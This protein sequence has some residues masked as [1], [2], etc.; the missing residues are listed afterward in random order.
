MNLRIRSRALVLTGAALLAVST[1]LPPG[2]AAAAPDRTHRPSGDGLSAVIRYTEYGIPHIVA[3]DYPSL[4][5]GEGWA[6]AADQVCVLADGFVTGRGERS[7]Y[8][9]PDAATDGS[10]SSAATNLT[11]D[12]FFRGINAAGTVEKLLAQPAPTGPS[13]QA[14]ELMRGYAAGYNAWLRQHR[15]TD[16]AC[17]GA[18]WVKPITT[19]AV[20]RHGYALALLSGQGAAVDGITGARPPVAGAQPGQ[21]P[22]RTAERRT[23][24][25]VA[26]ARRHFDRSRA[27]M[28][29]NAVAFSG[30]TTANGR[31]LL[32]GN[33]H[34]PWHGG[35][36]FWQSQVT[37]PGE[38]DAAGG[39]LL[40]VTSIS[41]GHNSRIAWSHTVAMGVPLT[42]RELTLVPNDP[43]S[44]LVDGRPV[45]MTKRT[46]TV[47]VRGA[48]G[49]TTEVTR[50]QWWSRYGPV[51]TSYGGIDL[52]WTAGSAYALDDA[53]AA[54]LRFSDAGL[55][56]S[57][58]RSVDGV[59]DALNRTQGLPWVNTIAADSGGH[60]LF[61]QSQVLPRLTDELVA[62]CSTALGRQIY[63]DTGLAVLDGSRGSCGLGRDADAVQDGIFGPSAMPTLKDAPYAENS[64]DS[65]WLANA[66]QPL[67]GYP[68]VFGDIGTQRSMRTRGAIEDVDAM[69]ERGRLTVAD[70]VKQQFAN[71]VPAADLAADDAAKACAALPGGTA[72]DS[73]G[74]RV[75][76]S[77]AC[78]VLA[79]WDRTV[80][81][82][83]AG[84]LLFD[85]FWRRLSD[86]TPERELWRV[87]F[88]AADPV[89]TPNTL[90][91]ADPRFA[92]SLADAVG[93]LRAARISLDAPLGEHQF[94]VR[95]GKRIPVSGGTE[96]LGVWNKTE[97]E[98]DSAKGGYSEVVH[99]SSYIQ[100]VGFD[101]SGCPNART[102]L[103]YSQ[104]SNPN[105]P[106]YSDQTE[107]YSAGRMVK[108]R[109]CAQDI[110]ASPKLRVV[111]VSEH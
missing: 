74:K 66:D 20:A 36:R 30:E 102:L 67:T 31:G 11:S 90:N 59:R 21:A 103:T 32:I 80:R 109:F 97:A 29:S 35:R 39:S 14:K 77:A 96:S 26:A 93:E 41:I 53:N 42:L 55:S 22:R 84:A 34:Y 79:G 48:D 2:A 108:E 27:D 10:L 61:T 45:K 111:R 5:F 12:L 46:V 60:S 85:R 17:R 70:L 13:R 15:V 43:T 69:A 33:P 23:A 28:G 6:Q 98:W 104:S 92:R 110:L 87:P 50:T 88:S 40:G 101:G 44:Y 78:D 89:A 105:S 68:P 86:A 71:R 8:F 65:A 106:H 75:D 107:L 73:G 91:T 49:R 4:G 63:P 47:P 94:V 25:Q 100:A 24:D 57:K 83:S 37:I 52:P 7:R 9:G 38:L 51:T 64:N 99:G 58:A 56:L 54:N 16:P 19:L 82:D 3:G 1:A 81:T 76:V 95:G 72:V 62:R 18:A